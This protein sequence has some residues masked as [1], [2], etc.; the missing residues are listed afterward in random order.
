M[1]DRPS[2][3]DDRAL[4]ETEERMKRLE[5][6]AESFGVGLSRALR[7]AVVDGRQLDTV[8][9]GLALRFS[10]RMLQTAL[11]PLDKAIGDGMA[12]AVTGAVGAIGRV[13]PFAKGGVVASPTYFPMPG[14]TGLA[15]EA[16][17]EAILPLARGP[18]G[19]LGVRGEG[20]GVHVT[21]NVT[22]TDADS[23]R[24]SE[25]QV[26]AMLARAVGRGRRGL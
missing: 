13:M 8:L 1:R 25:A 23:F 19:R 15:G 24:R 26:S 17:P 9:R 11:A 22:A 16:G 4:D 6:A 10:D 21:F 2:L 5:K 7:A 20:G 12:R 14:G 18:D 3:F